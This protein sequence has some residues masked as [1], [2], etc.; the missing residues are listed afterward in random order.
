MYGMLNIGT[1]MSAS[2]TIGTKVLSANASR[3]DIRLTFSS[4]TNLSAGQ[5]L[6]LQWTNTATSSQ[7][8]FYAR[9]EAISGTTVTL[10][11]PLPW[12]LSTSITLRYSQTSSG[13]VSCVTSMS[14]P[15]RSGPP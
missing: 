11:H 5:I 13:S 14:R 3:G 2:G 12:D 9:I 6:G 4:V 1:A 15:Q 10:S 7:A 8:R